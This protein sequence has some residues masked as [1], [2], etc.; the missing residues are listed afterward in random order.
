MMLA[1][2]RQLKLR[3]DRSSSSMVMDSLASGRSVVFSTTVEEVPTESDRLVNTV[4]WSDRI[5]APRETASLA[6]MVESVQTSKVSL[7]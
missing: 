6:V 7:S 3:T 1:R 4:R 5:F 2:F